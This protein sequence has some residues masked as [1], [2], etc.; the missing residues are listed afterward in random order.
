MSTPP[1][2]NLSTAVTAIEDYDSGLQTSLKNVGEM[3]TETAKVID[4]LDVFDRA[5]EKV[6]ALRDELDSFGDDIGKLR[7]I[8]RLMGKAG[9][10]KAIAKTA[11]EMLEVIET[12]TKQF[13]SRVDSVVK[14]LE[15]S[16]IKTTLDSVNSKVMDF[17]DRLAAVEG[18]LGAQKSS[19]GQ[20]RE[21]VGQAAA[22]NATP[23]QW[24]GTLVETPAALLGEINQQYDNAKALLDS[25]SADVPEGD[26]QPIIDL[27]AAV[28]KVTSLLDNFSKPLN[29]VYKLLE[30]IEPLLAAVD[31]L[32][33]L[34][35]DP[36]INKI[37]EAIGIDDIIDKAKAQVERLL[38][39]LSILDHLDGAFDL[40]VTTLTDFDLNAKT[41]PVEQSGGGTLDVPDPLGIV[42]WVE[43][44]LKDKLQE[45]L[46]NG[47]K[48]LIADAGLSA[49][50]YGVALEIPP[51]LPGADTSQPPL[52]GSDNDN[53]LTALIHD[54]VM[55]GD[56]HDNVITALGGEN[57]LIGGAG[58]DELIGVDGENDYFAGGQGDD[59]LRGGAGA[60]DTAFYFGNITQYVVSRESEN[61]PV[62]VEHIS[63]IAGV[64]LDGR[65]TLYDIESLEFRNRVVDVDLLLKNQQRVAP[66]TSFT[67]PAPVQNPDGSYDPSFLFADTPG[68]TTGVTMTGSLGDDV[69]AGG[70]GDDTLSGGA[71]NDSFT[72]GGGDDAIDG[73]AGIDTFSYYDDGVGGGHDIEVDLAAGSFRL[74]GRQ[75]A[76]LTS[77]ENVVAEDATNSLLFGDANGNGLTGGFSDDLIDGRGGNDAISG[78]DGRDILI[79][80]LGI[81]QL[82]GGDGNDYLVVGDADTSAAQRYDGGEGTDTLDYSFNNPTQ[83]N[84][85]LNHS[86]LTGNTGFNPDDKAEVQ[87][88][89]G[90]VR[91]FAGQG[92]VERMAAD[93]TTVLVTEYTQSI[94]S[95]VGSDF[96]DVIH[97]GTGA[98]A[99]HSLDGA[100]GDDVIY[101][102]GAR[103]T[104]RTGDG[105][106][107]VYAGTGGAGYIGDSE[108]TLYLESVD[109]LRWHVEDIGASSR[110]IQA[111]LA[112]DT[113]E[114]KSA[115][116]ASNPGAGS[117]QG[118]GTIFGS[119]FDDSFDIS[120]SGIRD[121][122]AVVVHGGEGDDDFSFHMRGSTPNNGHFYEAH[123]EA[124]ND[125]F[126]VAYNAE[127]DGGDGDDS[128]A[129]RGNGGATRFINASGGTGTDMFQV[130]RVNGII[131]GGEG[132]DIVSAFDSN[133]LEGLTVNLLAQQITYAGD[134]SKVTT[135]RNIEV[136]IGSDL[137][138]DTL[139][140]GHLGDKLI[141]AGGNDVLEGIM[142]ARNAPDIASYYKTTSSA[143]KLPLN[144]SWTIEA[145]FQT[146]DVDSDYNRLISRPIG[147]LQTFSLAVRNGDGHTRFDRDTGGF[148]AISGGAVADGLTHHMAGVY[149]EVA[150]TFE[151]FVDGVSVDKLVNLQ[152]APRD[153]PAEIFIGRFSD[154]SKQSFDGVIEEIR[155]WDVARAAT[156]ISADPTAIT[157]ANEPDLKLHMVG[158]TADTQLTVSKGAAFGPVYLDQ[159]SGDDLLYGGA[160]ND[161]LAGGDGDDLLH[162]GT[163]ADM[164]YGGTGR[165]TASY[166]SA[167]P[168]ADGGALE[169]SE[170]NNVTVDLQAGTAVVHNSV[171]AVDIHIPNTLFWNQI[172]QIL[173][174]HGT[175]VA[176]RTVRIVPS[177][178][179]AAG[180]NLVATMRTSPFATV[181][182][183]TANRDVTETLDGIEN[184][185][186]GV[187]ADTILGDGGSNTLRGGA[188]ADLLDGRG[189]DDY[190]GLEGNDTAR[191]GAGNDTFFIG[192]GALTIDGGS[193]TDTLDFGELGTRL[194]DITNSD[195]S[196]SEVE[197]TV[198]LGLVRYDMAGGFYIADFEIDVPVW[199]DTGTRESR[200]GL[201]PRAVLETDAAY[202][203]S[204]DD[205]TR[206]VPTGT[207]YV[208]SFEKQIQSFRGD[209]TNIEVIRSSS[210]VE[211]LQETSTAG[212]DYI[213]GG[214]NHDTLN[215]LAG[216]DILIGDLGTDHLD[217]GVGDDD[218]RGGGG[219]DFLYVDSTGDK[220]DG[221][222]G[223]DRVAIVAGTGFDVDLATWAAI[224]EVEGAGGDDTLDGSKAFSRLTLF[225]RAG[226]DELR[227][228]FG[229][230]QLFGGSQDDMLFGGDSTDS[231]FGDSGADWM[232][233]GEQ[234]D[235]YAFDGFDT[236]QDSG[237]RGYDK[238]QTNDAAGVTVSLAGWSGVERINGFTGNDRIN[239]SGQTD[240]LLL[241]GD[242]G[243][244]ILSGGSGN[245][246]LIGGDGNDTLNGGGGNDFLLGGSGDDV[247]DGGA[248]NDVLYIGQP[249]DYVFDGG[250]G[251]DKAVV[252]DTN[253]IILSIGGWTGVER[254]NGLTGDDNI[255]ANG[256]ATAI[257]LVGSA[258]H[259][260]LA[261]GS[262]GDVLYGG[263]DDDRLF[264]GDGADALIGS[265]GDDYFDGGDGGDFY[266]G[267]AGLDSF[268]W[269]AGFGRDVVKDYIDGE[270]R[271]DFRFHTGVTALSDLTIT[272][273]GAHTVIRLAAG[274]PD[275]ITLAD[276][277]ATDLTSSDFDFV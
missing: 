81:D 56:Q 186:G 139:S 267:G 172:D 210:H 273:S 264:G 142:G 34:T 253:G 20:V 92:K 79:G 47:A 249:G 86:W 136:L 207:Q 158:G 144:G 192:A 152:G 51:H 57:M 15:K 205:L 120:R 193:G 74:T 38:P 11:D 200:G 133:P 60:M 121:E 208:V 179:G 260:T 134:S 46:L 140:G 123:G 14:K 189:G 125:H 49:G 80:G 4:A 85:P 156:Q 224:E 240:A 245:D 96:N 157:A 78:G 173:L 112:T 117:V 246:V 234:S 66:G 233:G 35:I 223:Y 95:Y 30:P 177:E 68:S 1:L 165:D 122:A 36:V 62:V 151:L 145:W 276:V 108:D 10:L 166:A 110:K 187:G 9:A 129:L 50:G 190:F 204:A 21:V 72:G 212:D 182:D 252:T 203:N 266:L 265:T 206:V 243:D 119:D 255:E 237:T 111:F 272:Q 29:E 75:I 99:A 244:D 138:G 202:A 219:D 248:G 197:Q 40:A 194:L 149:D 45:F 19:F 124:G 118:F 250:A 227:G 88:G 91:I 33:S 247:F 242:A 176:T 215:G 143:S 94:E 116:G 271:L 114:I 64:S 32:A 101:A 98:T 128:F 115:S 130:N 82:F 58:E 18:E 48:T 168:G 262:A 67:A 55:I 185:V 236:I 71:G 41:Y 161:I 160:G 235:F 26:F 214:L 261:G 153:D 90:P 16:P 163:G 199:S 28:R 2:L 104:I 135:L 132:T 171:A 259:D 37:Q 218:M 103:G 131:D 217:G 6:V 251:F 52:T 73:G 13:E 83:S 230:D 102:E 63:P 5:I 213:R 97:G 169:V 258:G 23:I 42:A 232:D 274:G 256:L 178:S 164:L 229:N 100:G 141:G 270:D 198:E 239:G 222:D 150:Q 254:V 184:V 8:V 162:G 87:Q 154:T 12:K 84:G 175:L 43:G 211:V 188:G 44:E 268:V 159:S 146:T 126:A 170:F 39:S 148:Y 3:R 221:G 105:V 113:V 25:F 196:V 231:L 7:V 191:G 216:N 241:F 225:G 89:S 106:D 226:Q 31:F 147:G 53:D 238:A 174:Q 93:L 107:T 77:I 109:D 181:T 220:V 59:T 201:S 269:K 127:L 76:T 275:K 61:A 22:F 65:D 209:F 263:A 17:D 27:D 180:Q 70:A 277:L 24:T 167:A 54:I 183:T 137:H 69:I 155:V 195:G 257:T 228:G